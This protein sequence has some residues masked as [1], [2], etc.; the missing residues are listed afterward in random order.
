MD[1]LTYPERLSSQMSVSSQSSRS[2]RERLQPKFKVVGTKQ[3]ADCTEP[4][5]QDWIVQTAKLMWAKFLK[6]NVN[7]FLLS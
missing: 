2:T 1:I 6:F 7:C 5:I 4:Q 3:L